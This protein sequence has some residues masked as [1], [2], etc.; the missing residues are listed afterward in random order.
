VI[1]FGWMGATTAD[2]DISGTLR[3]RN[4][5]PRVT[6]VRLPSLRYWRVQR[7]WHQEV[8]AK[9]A[10]VSMATLWRI[11]TG[12]PATLDTVRKLAE[13]LGVTPAQ[14]QAQPPAE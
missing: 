9:Q 10:G 11:E 13:A 8:L 5:A 7:A 14:L 1:D 6:T 2:L 12:R 4:V 3:K